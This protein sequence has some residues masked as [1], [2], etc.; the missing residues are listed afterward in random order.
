MP[1]CIS[2]AMLPMM[3][4]TAARMAMGRRQSSNIPS[5]ESLNMRMN[6]AK[7]ATLVPVAMNAVIGVGAPS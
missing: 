5:N 1:G 7:A 4:V 3:I 6:A 2:A